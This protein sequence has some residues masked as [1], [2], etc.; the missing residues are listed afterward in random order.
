M[1]PVSYPSVDVLQVG[2]REHYAVPRMLH[3]LGTL[4]TLHTD[5][6]CGPGSWL[7]A[8]RNV[9]SRLRQRGA[10]RRLLERTSD[11]PSNV[12]CAHN[13]KG[14]AA[15]WRLRSA[16]TAES[17]MRIHHDFAKRLAQV[18]IRDSR[19]LPDAY[20]GF[21]G[22]GAL[23]ELVAG[24]ARCILDQIDGGTEEV[25]LVRKEQETFRSWLQEEPDWAYS[26]RTGEP[27]WLDVEAPRLQREWEL[28]DHIICNSEWTKRCLSTAGVDTR[29]CDVVPLMYEPPSAIP[30]HP[31]RAQH[32][33]PASLRVAFVG[34]LTLRK[35][36]HHV[37]LAARR[38][39]ADC[40]IEVIAA[41]GLG[42]ISQDALRPFQDILT[43]HGHVPRS[44]IAA[45]MRSCDILALPS[46]SDGFG[47]VQLEAMAQG[48]PVI[49]S[50]RTGDVVRHNVDGAR[51]PA[52]DTEALASIF[53][54]LA[55]D[56]SRL[57]ALAVKAQSRAYDFTFDTI[58]QRWHAV[59]ARNIG[60]A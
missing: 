58:A 8:L 22:V 19:G 7:H 59:L 53:C 57:A 6:Y 42:E 14:L 45:M 43:W 41:G 24:R 11:L 13:S 49:T 47:I 54:E 2:A 60:R 56:R 17:R 46:I 25:R 21:R 9:P 50:E 26:E 32:N 12:V 4:R 39:S 31:A 27:W 16:T 29:K 40:Q 35:G 23:F 20:V 55:R 44:K 48:L 18:V 36:I 28:A 34:T 37:L 1:S 3:S 52:G 15:Q 51:V 5:A 30:A 10:L 33:R 38:A